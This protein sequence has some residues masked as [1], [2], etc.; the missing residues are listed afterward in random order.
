MSSS[1]LFFIFYSVF[2]MNLTG[3]SHFR[4]DV[5]SVI[6]FPSPMVVTLPFQVSAWFASH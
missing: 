5:P 1:K 4:A 6:V 2:H 3:F